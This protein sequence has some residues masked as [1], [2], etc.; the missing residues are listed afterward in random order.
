MRVLRNATRSRRFV[1]RFKPRNRM[2]VPTHDVRLA[3]T[4]N[5]QLD[6]FEQLCADGVSFVP[7]A[8]LPPWKRQAA[9]KEATEVKKIVTPR[10]NYAGFK[11]RLAA[12][13]SG[14]GPGFPTHFQ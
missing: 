12:P 10:V 5:G 4:R 9:F 14:D 8:R 1:D 3:N 13:S 2:Y 6:Q 11:L 7:D